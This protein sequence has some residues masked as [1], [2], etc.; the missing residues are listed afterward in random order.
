MLESEFALGSVARIG[1]PQ[2]GMAITR[3]D[4]AG[5]ESGPDVVLDLLVGR[6]LA[7][8]GLHLAKPD[9]N[10]LVGETV[11]RASKTIEGSTIGEERIRQS[12]SDKFAGVG[13]DI[14]ALMI[15]E[16]KMNGRTRRA[17]IRRT[18]GW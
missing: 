3:D 13:R 7:N 14:T 2:D 15:T 1:F 8:L 6:F 10:L 9:K 17:V 18:C 5:L 16:C 4:L 12:G 11:K